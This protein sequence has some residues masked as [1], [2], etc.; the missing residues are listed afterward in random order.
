MSLD[1]F[2][3][4]FAN[5]PGNIPD[6]DDMMDNFQK[7][8]TYINARFDAD[9]KIP[10]TGLDTGDGRLVQTT[11]IAAASAGLTLSA[12]YADVVGATVTFTPDVACYALVT[13][14]FKFQII[15]PDTGEDC[16][17][18]GILVVDGVAESPEAEFIVGTHAST[19][20]SYTATVGQVHR[21]A[22]TAAAHTLK[23]QA[24]KTVSSG[25]VVASAGITNTRFLYQLVAQ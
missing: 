2:D 20:P 11:G 4:I 10:G 16:S 14:F 23:L 19:G 24:K 25:T 9:N 1:N 21:V 15:A 13:T 12:S 17:C 7:I 8:R 5:G 18:S 6:A 3:H 22:L